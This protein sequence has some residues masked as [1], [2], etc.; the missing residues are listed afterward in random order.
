MSV[1][2][3]GPNSASNST[4]FC[5]YIYQSLST[6][7]SLQ[8]TSNHWWHKAGS[9]KIIRKI[10]LLF[11]LQ[12]IKF[13]ALRPKTNKHKPLTDIQ[14][15]VYSWGLLF[16]SYSPPSSRTKWTSSYR[17]SL[18]WNPDRFFSFFAVQVLDFSFN[19]QG[20]HLKQG[21]PSKMATSKK[22]MVSPRTRQS[23][24]TSPHWASLVSE[25]SISITDHLGHVPFLFSPFLKFA[26][27]EWA[28]EP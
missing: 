13:T 6:D 10:A 24:A 26:N 23:Q 1:I 18:V 20:I 27:S 25:N 28:P 19:C 14:S 16:V 22:H 9:L 15:L 7:P 3:Q 5:W 21:S 2:I 17:Q 11:W 8:A 4:N 12:T